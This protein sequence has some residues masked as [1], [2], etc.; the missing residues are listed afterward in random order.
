[1][2]YVATK[3]S[4]VVDKMKTYTHFHKFVQSGFDEKVFNKWFYRRLS[5]MFGLS[6]HYSRLSFYNHWFTTDNRRYEFLKKL[7]QWESR[8][9][10][11]LCYSDVEEDIQRLILTQRLLPQY[12][13]KAVIEWNQPDAGEHLMVPPVMTR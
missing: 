2:A 6:R 8:G 7:V 9:E 5:A 11:T 10:P 1:M 13:D 3:R 12:L 4:T